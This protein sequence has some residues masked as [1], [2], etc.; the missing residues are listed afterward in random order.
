V[1]GTLLA[2]NGSTLTL[3]TRTSQT[4]KIDISRAVETEQVANLNVGQSYTALAAETGPDGTLHAVSVM[5]A[6]SG[7]GAWPNDQR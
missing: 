2:I 3:L 4:V 6:K 1:T 7:Y 5:R